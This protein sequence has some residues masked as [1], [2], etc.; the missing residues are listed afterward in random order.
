MLRSRRKSNGKTQG[1]EKLD[2]DFAGV[3][4]RHAHMNDRNDE[5]IDV[6]CAKIGAIM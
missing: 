2:I 4:G 1:H 6:L 3:I 5:L